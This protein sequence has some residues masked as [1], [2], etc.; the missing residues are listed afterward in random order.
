MLG[1]A[2]GHLILCKG[3]GTEEDSEAQRSVTQAGRVCSVSQVCPLAG[4]R[5]GW[6]G[7]VLRPY[8]QVATRE[9]LL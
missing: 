3:E 6:Y 5:A 2:R 4:H 1:S 7:H 9:V 8:L